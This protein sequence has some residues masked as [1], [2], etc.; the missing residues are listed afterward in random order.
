MVVHH[1]Q[2]LPTQLLIDSRDVLGNVGKEQLQVAPSLLVLPNDHL[3]GDVKVFRFFGVLFGDALDAHKQVPQ[4]IG[5]VVGS[6]N[7]LGIAAFNNACSLC[8]A[9]NQS[10][11]SAV[12]QLTLFLSHILLFVVGGLCHLSCTAFIQT[13]KIMVSYFYLLNILFI[14]S[15][16][17]HGIK[18]RK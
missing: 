6:R 7:R 5:I 16:I 8:A 1:L 15:R 17:Y 3:L 11:I 13:P 14:Q 4:Q 18:Y 10:Y 9:H 2:H 12:I